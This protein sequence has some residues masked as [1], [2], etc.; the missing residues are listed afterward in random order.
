VLNPQKKAKKV[1]NIQE[2]TLKNSERSKL[3][4]HRQKYQRTELHDK[5]Y[6]C[7]VHTHTHTHTQTHISMEP[8]LI[9]T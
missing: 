1:N 8:I 5:E 6:I 2:S 9:E 7:S 4:E 3:E